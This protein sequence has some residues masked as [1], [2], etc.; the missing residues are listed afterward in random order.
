MSVLFNTVY[1]ASSSSFGLSIFPSFVLCL[2]CVHQFN[3]EFE[4]CGGALSFFLFCREG[5]EGCFLVLFIFAMFA[6]DSSPM[7]L[8]SV[9]ALFSRI[10]LCRPVWGNRISEVR[11]GVF[12]V[13]GCDVVILLVEIP[14]WLHVYPCICSGC[15]YSLVL[16]TEWLVVWVLLGYRIV[17]WLVLLLLYL[18]QSGCIL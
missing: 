12:C 13:S 3:E 17:F 9:Y 8:S 16:S 7:L 14:L 15:F 10:L 6:W 4:F 1:V 2:V 5:Q 18:C 11:R